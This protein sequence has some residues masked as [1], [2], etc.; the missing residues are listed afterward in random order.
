MSHQQQHTKL[1]L[2]LLHSTSVISVISSGILPGPGQISECTLSFFLELTNHSRE[3]HSLISM[4]HPSLPPSLPIP[5]PPATGNFLSL[6]LCFQLFI[7]DLPCRKGQDG[8]LQLSSIAEKTNMHN[9]TE[10]N[11]ISM[12]KKSKYVSITIFLL[13]FLCFYSIFF[14]TVFSIVD[15]FGRMTDHICQTKEF[16]I[17]IHLS[18]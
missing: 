6:L 10:I 4:H 12:N 14:I 17:I 15:P 11:N 1:Y 5:T 8:S 16:P 13:L 18:I 9:C 2:L 7:H 3:N